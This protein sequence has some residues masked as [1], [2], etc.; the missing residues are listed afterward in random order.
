[1]YL[2][3]AES[4]SCFLSSPSL[5]IYDATCLILNIFETGLQSSVLT[6]L[7]LCAFFFFK[8]ETELKLICCDILDVLDKHLIPA[9]NTG[10]S[11]VFYY[12]M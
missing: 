3:T 8:V 11:K 12:K 5:G 1:M 6:L 10:E 2:W 9:A 4:L 7:L